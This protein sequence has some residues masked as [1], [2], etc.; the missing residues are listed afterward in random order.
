MYQGISFVVGYIKQDI[1]LALYLGLGGTALIFAIIVPPWPFL[2]R[3]PL[4]WLP[5]AGKEDFSQ[6]IV[7]DG[8]IVG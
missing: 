3:R 5:V 4:K 1:K 6:G 2:N 8:K 7:V